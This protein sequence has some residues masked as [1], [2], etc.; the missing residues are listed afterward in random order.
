[1]QDHILRTPHFF[2]GK[3]SCLK[4]VFYIQM[5]KTNFKMEVKHTRLMVMTNYSISPKELFTKESQGLTQSVSRL[6]N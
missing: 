2:L 6:L 5:I 1:M 3:K 4:W